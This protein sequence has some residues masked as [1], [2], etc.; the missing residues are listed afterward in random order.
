MASRLKGGTIMK[1]SQDSNYGLL[2][3]FEIR[4]GDSGDDSRYYNFEDEE[5]R[6]GNGIKGFSSN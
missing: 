6:R 3:S 2:T 5:I 4:T 1:G